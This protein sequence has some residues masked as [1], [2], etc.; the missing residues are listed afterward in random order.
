MRKS[1]SRLMAV[2]L[3]L[4]LI[5]QP[6]TLAAALP[7]ITTP[8]TPG[9]YVKTATGMHD[10]LVVEVT[11]GETS[12]ESIVIVENHETQGVADAALTQFPGK[13]VETQNLQ[14]DAISG[15]TRTCEGIIAAVTE[16]IREAGGNP[17]EFVAENA[18]SEVDF[19][20]YGQMSFAP[21][22]ASWDHTYDIV[23]IGGGFA[24][25]A[26]THTAKELGASTV[27]IEK[28]PNIGGNA[29][30]NGGQF[31]AYTSSIADDIYASMGVEPDTFA[32]HVNDTIN[33]GDN[34]GERELVEVMVAGF[35][36]YLNR[37]LEEG[38][39]VRDAISM[40]GGHYSFRTYGTV[41]SVGS[42][43]TQLQYQMVQASGADIMMD[44]KLVEIYRES[45]G[46]RRV[47]GV[48]VAA[49]DGYKTIKADRGVILCTGG[50]GANVE[51]RQ[52][53]VP[54]LTEE[55][56]TTN[57]VCATGEG[58]L[59][60][61]SVGANTRQM[62]QIQLYPFADPETGILDDVAVIPFSLPGFGIVYVDI[63]GNRYV[64]ETER[65][66]VC[67][68]AAMETD[69][70]ATFSI[71]SDDILWN[72]AT[73]KTVSEGIARGRII[74]ADTLEELAESINQGTYQGE[75]ISMDPTALRSSIERHNSFI[76]SG[77]DEDFG[78]RISDTMLP[79]NPDEGPF[80]A[81]AQWPSIHHTMGGLV[82]TKNA[83]VKD[84]YDAIIPGFFAAGEVTS[85]I[86]GTNR[87]G[88][89]AGSDACA[90]GMVAGVYA[91]TGENPVV[92]PEY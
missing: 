43:T 92:I 46:E 57:N 37:L 23:V 27:L 68:T 15:A 33:G 26:A 2:L 29:A 60:A 69:G 40:P 38:W 13:L 6:M 84:V 81:I 72:F 39:P 28:M 52:I 41:N 63:H 64:A 30:I 54:Y 55:Y 22:P 58:I 71:L 61:Q 34:F 86:H 44:T 8:M 73:E 79:I 75:T 90:F 62:D 11:L 10:G 50:F 77:V 42:D 12:I 19:F 48:R 4:A 20:D 91:V 78:A 51:M 83:E 24:G 18:A 67:A 17:E 25:L 59:I 88:S 82:I 87:L 3:L 9:T 70:R 80:Y 65:R 76:E 35:P 21:V 1:L 85:G 74:V 36:L 16:A 45:E 14:T 56:P 5:M 89:N 47:V 49:E 66:D 31:A 7:E 53:H 32:N